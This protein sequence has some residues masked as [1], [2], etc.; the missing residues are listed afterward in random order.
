MRPEIERPSK[1]Y[2]RTWGEKIVTVI[3]LL[4]FIALLLFALVAYR[5]L[6]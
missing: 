2:Y 1:R 5:A 6:F 4:F 3:A